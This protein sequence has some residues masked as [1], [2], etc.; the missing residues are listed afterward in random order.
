MHFENRMSRRY[1]PAHYLSKET[2]DSIPV[3]ILV[4][5]NDYIL[6]SMAVMGSGY[7][8]IIIV[9]GFVLLRFWID[10]LM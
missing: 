6:G 3:V 7:L 4:A 10:S 9:K 1:W 5:L 8:G 2:Y